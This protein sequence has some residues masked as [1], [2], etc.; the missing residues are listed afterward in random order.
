MKTVS[1]ALQK[2]G[3]GKTSISVSVAYELAASGH[4]VLLI[5]AD[6]QGNSTGW[7]SSA[8]ADVAHELADVLFGDIAINNAIVQTAKQGLSLLPTAGLDGRLRLYAETAAV[9]KPFAMK[10]L[11]KSIQ[12]NFDF[13]IIDTSPAFGGVERQCF[14]AS[15]EVVPTLQ[16]DTFSLDGLYTFLESI[17]QLK[18]DY[19]T[20]APTI[21]RLVLNAKDNRITQ[22]RTTLDEFKSRY[23]FNLSIIPVDQA[24]KRA[25]GNNTFVQEVANVKAE[26]LQAIKELANSI[27]GK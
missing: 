13:A 22:Q 1:F 20:N 21:A 4:R 15:N 17:N 9:S 8:S 6:P 19:E 2:G 12:G 3:T 7:L 25:Q 14:L 27:G 24:F 10:Q 23:T 26:T 11:L 5:D 16:L 18:A